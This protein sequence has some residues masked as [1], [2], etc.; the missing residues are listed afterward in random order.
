[1]GTVNI[2]AVMEYITGH[3]YTLFFPKYDL[4]GIKSRKDAKKVLA[5]VLCQIPDELHMRHL[6][7]EWDSI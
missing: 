5:S 3:R 6:F 1:M 4:R 7:E 2:L